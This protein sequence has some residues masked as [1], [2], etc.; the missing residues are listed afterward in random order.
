MKARA[1]NSEG[2]FSKEE[3]NGALETLNTCLDTIL[4]LWAP[5]MPMLTSHIYS[6]LYSKDV[7]TQ[8]FVVANGKHK[9]ELVTEEVC[10]LNGQIW[11]AKK[12]ASLSLKAPV[13][14][15][16]MPSKFKAIEKDLLAAHTIE[17]IKW[18]DEVKI[19]L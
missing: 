15:L 4:L 9:T 6:V 18:V 16:C 1:Y 7:H 17:K 2:K 3:Q 5:V 8:K 13:K 12:D 10:A 19:T 14:E 11:K